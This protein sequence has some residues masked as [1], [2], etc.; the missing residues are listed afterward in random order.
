MNSENYKVTVTINM[1]NG[2]KMKLAPPVRTL[3]DDLKNGHL[4]RT[5]EWVESESPYTP[6]YENPF[7]IVAIKFNKE[8]GNLESVEL[9][10]MS[11]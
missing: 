6:S 11:T 9:K 5:K 10:E 7:K 2:N 1:R 4:L 3:V 8:T